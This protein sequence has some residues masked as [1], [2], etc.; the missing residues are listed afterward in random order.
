MSARVVSDVGNDTRERV[1]SG[2]RECAGYAAFS[3]AVRKEE[4]LGKV[5][6]PERQV[7]YWTSRQIE[8]ALLDA[9]YTVMVLPIEQ[10]LEHH[11]PADH[12][13]SSELKLFGL[14]YKAL[15]QGRNGDYWKLRQPQHQNMGGFDWIYYGLSELKSF[16]DSR[17]SLHALRIKTGD[18][19]Y[20]RELSWSAVFPYMRWHPFYSGLRSCRCG[21][22]V[23]SQREVDELLMPFRD[24]ISSREFDMLV[25][26]FALDLENR[27]AVRTAPGIR[28]ADEELLE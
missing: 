3:L 2:I 7:E 16:R 25:D 28:F 1:V 10:T 26:F 8:E 24:R 6:L 5:Y 11:L 15:Y 13:I 22:K 12:L 4:S 14:Q 17:G 20:V 19:Q 23:E 18:F 9:G 21:T 27:S